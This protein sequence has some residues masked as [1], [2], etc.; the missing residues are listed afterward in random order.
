[1]LSEL[2]EQ[3]HFQVFSLRQSLCVIACSQEERDARAIVIHN[4]GV[5]LLVSLDVMHP[6]SNAGRACLN[7]PPLAY[8]AASAVPARIGAYA[9]QGD[10]EHSV[11][12]EYRTAQPKVVCSAGGHLVGTSGTRA[13][14]NLSVSATAAIPKVSWIY[15]VSYWR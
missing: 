11:P 8:A 3:P 4:V 9:K 6:K 12:P 10:L 14:L 2:S 1:M 5:L 13:N 7:G 15:A